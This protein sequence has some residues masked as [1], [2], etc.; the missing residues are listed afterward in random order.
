MQQKEAVVCLEAI[1]KHLPVSAVT[2]ER[3]ES[4]GY[5]LI[6]INA[7]LSESEKKAVRDI[8]NQLCLAVKDDGADLIVYKP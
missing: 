8:A 5:K 4:T 1:Y 6:I 3:S 7:A 2:F